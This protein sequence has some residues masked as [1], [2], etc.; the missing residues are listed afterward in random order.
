MSCRTLL[1]AAVLAGC[2]A[3]PI[4]DP[5]RYPAGTPFQPHYVVADSTRLRYIDAG[6]GTPVLFIHGL[7]AS[8]YAWRRNLAPVMS[9]GFRVVALDTRG[10]GSSDKPAHGY[11]NIDLARL[12]LALM[13]S[14]A[15]TDAV[16]VGH[17]MGGAIAAE[18]AISYPKRV[19][20]L[21]LIDAA[22]VGVR[23]PLVF[24][25]ARWPLLGP[26]VTALRGR[27]LT[28]RILKSTYADPTKVT[29]QDVDQYY[30]P[31]ADPE[32]ARALRA[33]LREFR[34]DGLVGRLGEI[35]RPTLVLW[36]AEDRWIP[37]ATGRFLAAQLVRAAF[38]LIP[39]AGHSVQEEQ[40][41]Q[42][43]RLLIS[44]LREGLPRVPQDLARD[45]GVLATAVDTGGEIT[46]I[47][48]T[49]WLRKFNT[50]D[51][52]SVTAEHYA[53]WPPHGTSSP[54]AA[55]TLPE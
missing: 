24:R 38:L 40:P 45:A 10:S 50:W 5:V 31:V 9:A 43:N 46:E 48:S 28:S 42:V 7:G 16:L 2:R 1:A 51:V 41:D 32:Y 18:V 36:G 34:F 39:H 13:D 49:E 29:E 15:L 30:A 52:S 53:F 44:F 12:V 8:I 37:P 3:A 27:G 26:L 14:L 11:R 55:S 21:V 54:T 25:A 20:A 23:E 47:S 4:P 6:R 33:A 17:S 35:D 22:G 19:R